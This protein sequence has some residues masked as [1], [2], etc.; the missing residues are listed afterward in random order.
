MTR[1]II[2]GSLARSRAP[3]GTPKLARPPALRVG[4]ARAATAA[5]TRVRSLPESFILSE[6]SGSLGNFP[7]ALGTG[8]AVIPA[9]IAGSLAR[10]R[11]SARTMTLCRPSALRARPA[12]AAT[13]PETR[14]RSRAESFV[15]NGFSGSLGNRVGDLR[16][17]EAGARPGA[18]VTA[19]GWSARGRAVGAAW[20]A[21]RREAAHRRRLRQPGLAPRTAISTG[22]TGGE[23][24]AA[25]PPLAIP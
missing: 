18:V 7:Q 17:D 2:G 10:S 1:A 13:T 3:T 19:P 15:C 12:R 8:E 9:I 5:E 24:P 23:A 21:E 16:P 4:P 14:V 11:A 22:H 25:A 6:F 20:S